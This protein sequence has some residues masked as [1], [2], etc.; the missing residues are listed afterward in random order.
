MSRALALT[1]GA[2]ALLGTTAPVA[3]AAPDTVSYMI[4]RCYDP[5]QPVEQQPESV[6]YNCDSTSVM[7]DMTWSSWGPEATGSGMD[8][9]VQCQPDCAQGP[10]LYNPILVHAWNAKAPS[11]P[12]CPDGVLFYNDLT[13]A[14]P[15]SAPPWVT[16]GTSW[17]D[18]VD[19]ITLNGMPAVHF[20]D[21]GPH[22]CTPLPH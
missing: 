21:Q 13:V 14:Y 9:S 18:T 12:G 15:E 20:K 19:Y 3:T 8:N 10:H 7:E 11:V 4:G 22:S 16:P 6:V 17:S 2:L 5:S 1:A